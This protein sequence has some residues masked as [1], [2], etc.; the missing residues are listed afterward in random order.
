MAAPQ[1]ALIACLAIGTVLILLLVP[2]PERWQGDWQ[3]KFFDLGHVPLFAGLTLVLTSAMGGS[4]RWPAVI[5]LTLAALAEIAQDY[6]GRSASFLDFLRGS[7]GVGVA[8]VVIRAWKVPR[9]L[10]RLACH[11]LMILGLIAWPMADRGPYLL[12]AYEGW[13]SF[14]V[15]ADFRTPRELLRWQCQQSSLERIPDP[16]QQGSWLGRLEL[17]PGP[18]MYPGAALQPIIRDFTAYRRLCWSFVTAGDALTLVFSVRSGSG[19]PSDHYQFARTFAA[20]EHRVEADL[21]NIAPKA[22][23]AALDLSNIMIVQVFIV[24]PERIETVWLK[25]IWLE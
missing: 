18:E 2:L 22:E 13:W 11:G 25:R 8:V 7:L 23:P 24:Q 4:W 6:C 21:A 3:G 1:K 20:G 16:K 14:P 5:S 12:D 15:L 9:T 19:L 10:R 17:L